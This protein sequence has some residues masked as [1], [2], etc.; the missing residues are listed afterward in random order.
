M[1]REVCDTVGVILSLLLLKGTEDNMRA[2]ERLNEDVLHVLAKQRFW[3][4]F[5][6]AAEGA[7]EMPKA[8]RL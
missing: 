3:E 7:G 2:W 4:M 1:R 6:R 5:K 8:T